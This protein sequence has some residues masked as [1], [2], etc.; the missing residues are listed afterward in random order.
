MQQN[1]KVILTSQKN[2]YLFYLFMY[3]FIYFYLFIFIVHI[4]K[5]WHGETQVMVVTVMKNKIRR[6]KNN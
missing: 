5:K 2:I 6:E 4:D 3:L 1:V